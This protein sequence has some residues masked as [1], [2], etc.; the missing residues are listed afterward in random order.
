[1]LK[2]E[3]LKAFHLNNYKPLD[4][5]LQENGWDRDQ[6]HDA[7]GNFYLEVLTKPEIMKRAMKSSY[8]SYLMKIASCQAIEAWRKEHPLLYKVRQNN[9]HYDEVEQ[10]NEENAT[11]LPIIRHDRYEN[12]GYT[13][14]SAQ[15]NYDLSRHEFLSWC[16]AREDGFT[17]GCSAD[18]KNSLEAACE[19]I[20]TEYPGATSG[21]NAAVRR[22]RRFRDQ[23]RKEV[24]HSS[25][26]I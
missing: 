11:P 16:H 14:S 13:D 26:S 8:D 7:I 4:R 20:Q 3:D 19:A 2:T 24:L 10:D 1:M 21:G 18:D 17:K 15:I 22:F 5:C 23:Y 9:L 6:R 12:F 25:P